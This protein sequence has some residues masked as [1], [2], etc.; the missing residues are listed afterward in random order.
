M[1]L[2]K[3][4]DI[5]AKWEHN[6]VT[7]EVKIKKLDTDVSINLKRV[8]E[9]TESVGYWRKANQIHRW[10][11]MN[12][13]EGVDNCGEYW[14]SKEQFEKLL[15]DCKAVRDNK[16]LAAEVLP[17]QPGFFFGGTDYDEYYDGEIND[18]IEIVENVLKEMAEDKESKAYTSYYYSSSW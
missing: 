5:G 14:V 3:K 6:K 2:T 4:T 9:I 12:V 13:Q 11:V 7:G 18:T 17:T 15:V 16:A 8:S 10:F 1:Y